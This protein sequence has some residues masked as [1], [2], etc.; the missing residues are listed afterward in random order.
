MNGVEH[1]SVW[2]RRDPNRDDIKGLVTSHITV[3]I[4]KPW[5]RDD[6]TCDQQAKK[7]RVHEQ[8]CGQDMRDYKGIHTSSVYSI[9]TLC[10]PQPAHIAVNGHPKRGIGAKIGRGEREC[11]LRPRSGRA[12]P[13]SVRVRCVCDQT[14]HVR[15]V[16]PS[17]LWEILH[18]YSG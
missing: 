8:A 18:R 3:D 6:L 13:N 9:W 7:N 1:Y 10:A 5:R 11:F 16:V 4:T 14:T 15:M 12:L 2:S 17:V